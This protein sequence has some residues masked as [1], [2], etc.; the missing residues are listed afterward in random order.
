[1]LGLSVVLMLL[2]G[3]LLMNQATAGVVE[4]KR[5]SSLTEAVGVH[6]FMQ[7]QLRSPDVRNAP[8][9]ESLNRLADLAVAQSAQYRV[10]IDAP[11]SRLVSAGIQADSVPEALR[12][13][14]QASEGMY[15]TPTQVV[16]T[17]PAVTPEPGLAIGTSLLGTDG[18]RY[19][20][21]YIFPMTMEMSTLRSLQGAVVA[22]GA[23]LTLALTLVAYLITVQVVRPV[24]RASQAALR[25][26]SGRLD[27][28]IPVRGTEDL[29]TLARSM[30]RMAG[31][32][33]Q[34]I[35]ELETLS[36]LQ[37][38]FV[39]DVSH[40]LRTPMT[41]IKMASEVLHDGRESFDPTQRRSVE[42]MN[43]EIDRFELM[44]SDLLEISRFDAGAAE[45]A[46]DEVEVASLVDAEV[47]A[48]RSMAQR[49]G[50]EVIVEYRNADTRAAVDS[51][52]IRRIVRNLLTNAIE[53][54]EGQPIRVTVASDVEAVA[55]T[56][57]D[58]GVGFAP[59]DAAH[60]FDRFWRADPSRNR[61]VGGSGLGLSIAMEDARLHR[62]WLTAWG[63]PGR[64]AQFRLTLPRD[65]G[66]ELTGSPLPVIPTD[67]K[68]GARR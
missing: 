14:V 46:T 24:R 48:T 54:A 44:L 13:Q 66:R 35:R 39:S 28:R 12:T 31:Q 57:R 51:R 42:L 68:A 3:V 50:V 52:R 37:Q 15:V 4:A 62:G 11:T 23:A 25:L 9:H 36:T 29:A 43:T 27:E 26:A 59:E 10:V 19:P 21:Y 7:E 58:F 16:F 34:R 8:V 60:V 38:R 64:G 65:P 30:N 61:V 49:L 20:V 47:E 17:D 53:H 41:T 40:E 32:L 22:T 55:I 33:Q 18:E 6:A 45:L 2:A 1:M 56:V 67:R 5:E 63:R